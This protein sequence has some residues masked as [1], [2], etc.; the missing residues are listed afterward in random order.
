[1]S[2]TRLALQQLARW[3]RSHFSIPVIAVTGSVGKTTTKDLLALCL[4][5][6]FKTLKTRGNYNNEIGV[7]LTLLALDDSCQAAVVEMAMRNRGEIREL[8][9]MVCPTHAIITNVEPV[10]LENLGSLRA[11]A[12]AKCEVLESLPETGWAFINGDDA[13]LAETARKYQVKQILSV[14]V[15][16]V[17]IFWKG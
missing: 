12:E 16:T 1:M 7:P 11:I 9:G 5:A 4:G 8:A 15:R 10:H 14:P 3:H 6:R 2:D 17:P 13:L